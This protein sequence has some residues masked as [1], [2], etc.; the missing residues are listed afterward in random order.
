[1]RACR[2]ERSKQHEEADQVGDGYNQLKG[3]VMIAINPPSDW[4]QLARENGA[5]RAIIAELLIAN[6]KLRWEL[7]GTDASRRTIPGR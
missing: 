5:L 7:R 3:P 6:Q 4:Q 1:M 2:V